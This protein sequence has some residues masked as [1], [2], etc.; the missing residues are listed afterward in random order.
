MS[1]TTASRWPTSGPALEDCRAVLA[2][3]RDA[4]PIA[5]VLARCARGDVLPQALAAIDLAL[6]DLAGRRTA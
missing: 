2:G 1:P 6:W 4:A 5:D 3:Y